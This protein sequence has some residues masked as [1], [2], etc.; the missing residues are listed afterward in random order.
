MIPG[1]HTAVL[2]FPVQDS[3]I[4]KGKTYALDPNKILEEESSIKIEPSMVTARE[5]GQLLFQTEISNLRHEKVHFPEEPIRD[6]IEVSEMTED[7]TVKS[8]IETLEKLPGTQIQEL[9]KNA[10]YS[11]RKLIVTD[12]KE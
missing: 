6:L 10:S 3:K 11:I 1:W 4:E 2:Q 7:E 12:M 8:L 5:G 9:T